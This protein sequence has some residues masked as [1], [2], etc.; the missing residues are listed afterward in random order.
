M[1]YSSEMTRK[2]VKYVKKVV[3]EGREE[4]LRVLRV[5]TQQG[6]IDLSKKAVKTEEIEDFKEFYLK[7]KTVHGIMKLLSFKTK[8]DLEKLYPMVCWPLYK[9]YTHAHDGFKEILK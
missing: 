8:V 3:K 4:V 9:L 2:R 1:I 5:D 6:Y 7:S